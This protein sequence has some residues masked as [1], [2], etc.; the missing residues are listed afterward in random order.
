MERPTFHT[1][2][3]EHSARKRDAAGGG[4]EN[5]LSLPRVGF[6]KMFAFI[7]PLAAACLFS[8]CDLLAAPPP[9]PIPTV[10]PASNMIEFRTLSFRH[11]LVEGEAI[12]GT[13]VRYIDYQEEGR[14]FQLTINGQSAPK[15]AGDSLNWNGV[16]A[17][18]VLAN[19]DLDLETQTFGEPYTRGEVTISVLNPLPLEIDPLLAPVA[20]DYRFEQLQVDY[21]IPLGRELPGTQ[22]RFTTI[23]DEGALFEGMRAN[24]YPYRS[25]GDS[26]V[27]QGNL[28]EHV[29]LRYDLAVISISDN[30]IRLRGNGTLWINRAPL[31]Q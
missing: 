29:S 18:G 30:E 27:W 3:C 31:G 5:W 22:L 15:R 4:R 6:S 7:L 21:R 20:S 1:H 25:Q 12:P 13:Q 24:A 26:L 23:T 9:T 2:K 8:A 19:Y 10:T 14:T 28:S 16:L 17:P 11:A